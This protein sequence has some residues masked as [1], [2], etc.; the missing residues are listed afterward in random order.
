MAIDSGKSV[1]PARTRIGRVTMKNGGADVR[2]LHRIPM[3]RVADHLHAWCGQILDYERP[4]DAYAAV[5]LWFDPETPGRPRHQATYCTVHDAIP[6][7]LLVRM[8]G[9][10]L[11]AEHA[12]FTGATRAIEAVGSEIED[13]TPDGAA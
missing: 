4:P 6:A 12:A 11:V 3:G 9:P 13:W 2:V 7:P 8:A 5:A 1:K 10:Y